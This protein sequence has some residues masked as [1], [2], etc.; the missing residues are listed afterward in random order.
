MCTCSL[1]SQP[2]PGLQEEKHDQ[3]VKAGD[4][5]PMLCSCDTPLGVLN[6]VLE[7]PTQE[8]RGA[9]GAGPVH[10][11]LHVSAEV[12]VGGSLPES[13]PMSSVDTMG[14]SSTA[15]GIQHPCSFAFLKAPG[16]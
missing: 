9:V 8:G 11:A 15:A 5:A 13:I 10:G 7:P 1:E 4:S 16:K 6:P 12:D 3:Q 14:S 2:D